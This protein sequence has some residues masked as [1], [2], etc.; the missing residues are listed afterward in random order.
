VNF[1]GGYADTWWK[2]RNRFDSALGS[3][4]KN[5]D[6]EG[7]YSL[8]LGSPVLIGRADRDIMRAPVILAGG[9]RER[10]VAYIVIEEPRVDG[11]RIKRLADEVQRLARAAIAD[12]S[13]APET[14]RELKYP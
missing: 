10:S 13:S 2:L 5:L 1:V 8:R 3:I 4:S 14:D 9:Q 11:A 6:S 12:A 7:R